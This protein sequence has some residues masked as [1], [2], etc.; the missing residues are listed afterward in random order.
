M[1]FEPVRVR[2]QRLAEK[3][4]A[5]GL[6]LLANVK[7]QAVDREDDVSVVQGENILLT[8][9]FR[10]LDASGIDQAV[11]TVKAKI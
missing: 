8:R 9:H 2:A 1:S 4:Q 6:P 5:S 7:V 3:L 10:M 11:A